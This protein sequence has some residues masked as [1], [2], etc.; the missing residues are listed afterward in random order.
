[1][2]KL[3]IL[4]LIFTCSFASAQK[5]N[6]EVVY[7]VPDMPMSTETKLI[8]YSGQNEAKGSKDELFVRAQNFFKSNYKN[9]SGVIKEQDQEKGEIQGM[10]RFKIYVPEEKDGIK[11]EAGLVS[12]SIGISVEDGKYSYEITRIN[13]KKASY[14]GVEKWMDK[15]STSYNKVH[16]YYLIQVHEYMLELTEKLENLMR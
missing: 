9:P 10:S 4:A 15:E 1:M 8:T 14:F 2:N 6:K 5:K 11:R 16:D 12:Y 13:H 7:E 3:L